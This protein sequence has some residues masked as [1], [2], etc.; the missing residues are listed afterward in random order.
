MFFYS[1]S[2]ANSPPHILLINKNYVITLNLILIIAIRTG[3]EESRE[4]GGIISRIISFLVG[5]GDSLVKFV[6]FPYAENIWYGIKAFL[7]MP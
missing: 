1:P 4:D 2:F 7:G 3:P 6:P 5:V